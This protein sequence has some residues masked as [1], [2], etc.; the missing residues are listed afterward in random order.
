[1][2]RRRGAEERG[3]KLRGEIGGE[4][5]LGREEKTTDGKKGRKCRGEWKGKEQRKSERKRKGKD[6]KKGG[7]R[8]G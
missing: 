4:E 5:E 2:R 7:G 1:M 6:G 3:G 8:G